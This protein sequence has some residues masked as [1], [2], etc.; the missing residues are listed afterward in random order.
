MAIPRPNLKIYDHRKG[1]EEVSAGV[2]IMES[3]LD[4]IRQWKVRAKTY[5]ANIAN[6]YPSLKFE[7]KESEFDFRTPS[8]FSQLPPALQQEGDSLIHSI[9]ER[10]PELSQ[11]IR[12]SPLLTEV[13]ERDAGH[14]IKGMRAALRL[15]R[16]DYWD[17]QVINDEER[18]LGVSP[19]GQTEDFE[20][21][22]NDAV[23]FFNKFADQLENII[24]LV[25][26]SM[27]STAISPLTPPLQLDI[28]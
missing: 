25:A 22:P 15:R 8:I 4:D 9:T 18:I 12:H 2:L 5:F 1:T 27:P 3:I 23:F 26:E 11:A 24:S 19:P 17:P 21:H 16:Y 10:V 7:F 13:D 14:A 28:E 6:A 20:M